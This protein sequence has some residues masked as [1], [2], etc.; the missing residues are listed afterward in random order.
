ME[1]VAFVIALAIAYQALK[2]YRLTKQKTLWY[3]H[4]SFA[5][6]SVGLLI[7]SLAGFLGIVARTLRATIAF[8][9]SGYSIYFFAQLLAYSILIYAY[10][11]QTR[12]LNTPTPS[13]LL[14]SLFGFATLQAGPGIVRA[15]LASFVEYHPIPEI[16]LLL[17]VFYVTVQTS[18]NY[19]ATKDRN[20]FLVFLAFLLLAL[21]HL[22]FILQPINPLLF[23]IGHLLQLSG[24][25]S[26]LAM[27][28]Q[29]TRNQ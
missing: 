18:K 19:L 27:L 14:A 22:L 3:V 25:V 7:D 24:F 15:L 26:F 28:L 17:L 8:A 11:S 4:F 13:I 29:V 10:V 23:V 20:A 12:T 6:L 9:S 16:V 21:S 5:V 1:L 2:G